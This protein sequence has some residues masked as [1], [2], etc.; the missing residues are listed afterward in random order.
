RLDADDEPGPSPRPPPRV[1]HSCGV[2]S[3]GLRDGAIGGPNLGDWLDP[4]PL[5]GEHDELHDAA[6]GL[7]RPRIAIKIERGVLDR[8]VPPKTR[9]VPRDDDGVR[10]PG[11]TTR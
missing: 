5:V 1:P 8:I 6:H 3:P 9:P 2:R 11:S 10:V 4:R 7:R